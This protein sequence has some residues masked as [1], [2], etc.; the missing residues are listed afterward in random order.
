MTATE[1][2]YAA[3]AQLRA[4]LVA[5]RALPNRIVRLRQRAAVVETRAAERNL[6]AAQL[7]AA[8]IK[9]ALLSQLN[10]VN[11]VTRRLDS[12]LEQLRSIGISTAWAVYGPTSLGAVPAIPLALAGIAVAVAAGVGYALR[13]VSAQENLLSQ[14][15]RGVLTADEYAK[16]A[17]G[18][19]FFGPLGKSL[20]FLVAGAI[21][22]VAWPMLAR[23]T[24]QPKRRTA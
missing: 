8:A 4:Q 6:S 5:F 3:I 23:R 11:S 17:G 14:L 7:K 9:T 1:R 15:E 20:P 22:V 2:F 19:S 21:A 16:A 12:F 10:V 18:T 24:S 13:A